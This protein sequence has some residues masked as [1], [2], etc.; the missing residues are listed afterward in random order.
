MDGNQRDMA[1]WWDSPY[2]LTPQ[3]LCEEE[4]LGRH[5]LWC[6]GGNSWEPL[7][8]EFYLC[9]KHNDPDHYNTAVNWAW[10][11]RDK[12][13]VIDFTRLDLTLPILELRERW[14]ESRP[15]LPDSVPDINRIETSEK[16]PNAWQIK[17]PRL[18]G[19]VEISWTIT[20][21]F[22]GCQSPVLLDY[23]E[24]SDLPKPLELAEAMK[25]AAR[26]IEL[27]TISEQTA[28]E[29]N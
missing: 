27:L 9:P 29:N 5:W 18:K 26:N 12:G 23:L 20:D 1:G 15:F 13:E 17:D 22:D 3:W 25:K 24:L 7:R 19:C 10:E 2:D 6:Q 28:D 11:Q 4:R 14:E 21:I 8:Q 16:S